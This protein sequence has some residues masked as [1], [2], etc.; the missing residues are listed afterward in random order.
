MTAAKGEDPFSSC[1]VSASFLTVVLTLLRVGINKG[2]LAPPLE[3]L[4]YLGLGG[5]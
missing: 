1:V 3:S 4:I 5:M 2:S